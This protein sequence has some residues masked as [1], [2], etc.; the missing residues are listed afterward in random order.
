MRGRSCVKLQV[1]LLTVRL[2]DGE[3]GNVEFR[4]LRGAISIDVAVTG[5]STLAFV[6]LQ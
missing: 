1:S 5:V 3:D 2:T 6:R 4:R